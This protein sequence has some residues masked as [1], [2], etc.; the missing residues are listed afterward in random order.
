MP[1]SSNKKIVTLL[2][3]PLIFG[4]V[5]SAS[6][7]TRQLETCKP[8]ELESKIKQFYCTSDS[9]RK[10][11]KSMVNVSTVATYIHSHAVKHN[12]YIFQGHHA[13]AFPAEHEND[14]VNPENINLAL[15]QFNFTCKIFTNAMAI[16][17]QLQYSLFNG[18][19]FINESGILLK[20]TGDKDIKNFISVLEHL[21]TLTAILQDIE[22]HNIKVHDNYAIIIC[23]FGFAEKHYE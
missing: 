7:H 13:V 22:V 1:T 5:R 14:T 9:L 11:S 23:L 12:N 19:Y 4:A 17:H 16:K 20:A 21:E 18:T 2:I 15:Q 6:L 3:L 10:L 8:T